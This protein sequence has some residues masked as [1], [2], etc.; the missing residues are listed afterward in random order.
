MQ[1]F[2]PLCV[3]TNNKGT[4]SYHICMEGL[5]SMEQLSFTDAEFSNRRKATKR[6]LFLQEMES[7]IPFDEWVSIIEPYYYSNTKGC[8]PIAIETM[9]RMY[10]LQN[11]F[12]LSDEGIEDAIYDSYAMK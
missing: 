12:N 8:K 4:I 2:L 10:L 5:I 7:I 6:E 3:E 11:W 1:G 9:L